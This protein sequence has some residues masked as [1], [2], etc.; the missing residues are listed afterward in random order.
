MPQYQH[1]SI[2]E[3]MCV[4]LMLFRRWA[5]DLSALVSMMALARLQ[6]SSLMIGSWL[7]SM[8]ICSDRGFSVPACV[9]WL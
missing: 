4:Y 1:F 5:T 8:M 3:K 9:L 6:T 2:F 7:H